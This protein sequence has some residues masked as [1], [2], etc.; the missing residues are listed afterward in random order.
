MWEG[1]RSFVDMS[2]VEGD[3]HCK[4]TRVVNI[5]TACCWPDGAERTEVR[6]KYTVLVP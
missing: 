3:E 4:Y 6:V 1:D 2:R 5:V